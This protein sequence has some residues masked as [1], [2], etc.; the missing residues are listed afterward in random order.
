MISP[1]N[2]IDPTGHMRVIAT[3]SR[4]DGS[5]GSYCGAVSDDIFNATAYFFDSDTYT[6]TTTE[7]YA[8]GYLYT[9]NTKTAGFSEWNFRF[10]EKGK[11][12][13]SNTIPM[14]G[15]FAKAGIAQVKDEKGIDFKGEGGNGYSTISL[16]N[17]LDVLVGKAQAAFVIG[18]GNLGFVAEA[19][20][21][22]VSDRQTVKLEFFDWQMEIGAYGDAGSYGGKVQLGVFDNTFVAEANASSLFGYGFLFRLKPPQ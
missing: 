9:S 6:T 2:Y 20:V 15:I 14:Y 10:N 7:T 18:Q 3:H 8:N 4:Y 22:V 13:E 16:Y 17:V 12:N 1:I 11:F 19:K 21:S 5:N